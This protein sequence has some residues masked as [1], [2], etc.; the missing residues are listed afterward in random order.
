VV[1]VNK[2]SGYHPELRT[3]DE[4]YDAPATL[5]E[6]SYILDE[7]DQGEYIEFPAGTLFGYIPN[8]AVIN[9]EPNRLYIKELNTESMTLVGVYEGISW[10]FIF[11][12]KEGQGGGDTPGSLEEALVGS[13]TW[14]ADVNGHFGCGPDLGNPTGW[15]SGEAHCKDNAFMYNDIITFTADGKYTLDPV[16][17]KSYINK[18]VTVY[19]SLKNGECP[20]GDDFVIALDKVTVD[21]SLDEIGDFEVIKLADGGMFSYT[22]N[23]DFAD[24]PWLYVKSYSADQ[25]VLMSYTATGNGGGSIAWQFI[26]K[27][28]K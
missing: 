22:P 2:D 12:P 23:N 3:G 20:Y 8:A 9:D 19:N 6:S 26:L 24:E 17:G 4:D 14:D 10:Q 25:L 16:D 11:K 1:Y 13:W 21:Y 28:V 15:W 7:D 5:Q 27:R 18:D